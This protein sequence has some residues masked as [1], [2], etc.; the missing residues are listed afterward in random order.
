MT[1][2]EFEDMNRSFLEKQSDSE[3][4]LLMAKCPEVT[5]AEYKQIEHV[6]NFHPCISETCGKSQISQLYMTYGMAII[7]DMTLRA[8]HMLALEGKKKQLRHKMEEVNDEI[9]ATR[10]G[11]NM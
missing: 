6:Y 1:K 10:E 9:R 4:H 7:K 2:Q 3:L 5:D 8:D 11:W